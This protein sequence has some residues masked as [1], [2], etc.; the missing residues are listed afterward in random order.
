MYDANLTIEQVKEYLERNKTRG[1]VALTVL[2]KVVDSINVIFN[3]KVGRELLAED[4]NRFEVL[5]E[6]ICN[7]EASDYEKAEFWYIRERLVKIANKLE[8]YLKKLEEIK[9]N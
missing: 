3:T 4:M 9:G 1:G 5:L 6:K 8:I 2:S 7:F